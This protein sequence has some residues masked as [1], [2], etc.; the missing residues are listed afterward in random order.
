MFVYFKKNISLCY[1][2][3]PYLL[4]LMRK[5]LL[6]LIICVLFLGAP[7]FAA[8]VVAPA[9]KEGEP[10]IQALLKNLTI[11]EF[12]KLTPSQI[13][14]QTGKKLSLKETIALK[15]LQK[16]LKKEIKKGTAPKGGPKKQLVAFLLCWFLGFLGIHRFYLGHTVVGVVQLLTMGGCGI[17]VLIDF[18]RIIMNDL[19][20]KSGDTLESW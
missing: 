14:K 8:S 3:N 9:P 19:K 5:Q 6:L 7:T 12:V 2:I 11:E 20:T 4:L 1:Q 18:I 17:W 10:A 13:R 15:M 16:K